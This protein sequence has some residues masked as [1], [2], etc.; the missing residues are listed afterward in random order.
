MGL[1]LKSSDTEVPKV[2]RALRPTCS[3][4]PSYMTE[5]SGL[6]DPHAGGKE[7]AAHFPYFTRRVN[8]DKAGAHSVFTEGVKL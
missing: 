1:A 6:G 8:G 3:L 2:N 5:Q 4:M 7:A